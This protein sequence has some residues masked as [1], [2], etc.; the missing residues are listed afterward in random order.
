MNTDPKS[1]HSHC[2]N[3]NTGYRVPMNTEE[4]LPL[5]Q[6]VA[7]I[8]G[9][10]SS[11]CSQSVKCK[12]VSRTEDGNITSEKS[13]KAEG[14]GRCVMFWRLEVKW[15]EINGS[16]SAFREN[17][18]KKKLELHEINKE[19]C[20]FLNQLLT[21]Y[22][23]RGARSSLKPEQAVAGCMYSSSFATRLKN[24]AFSVSSARSH[25]F[26]IFFFCARVE[27]NRFWCGLT[28]PFDASVRFGEL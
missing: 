3:M 25:L 18:T 15:S 17:K 28:G 7:Y 10:L 23:L 5:Q 20:P 13:R 2:R 27:R 11:T 21:E 12:L 6:L 19:R 14:N 8:F 26:F 9:T 16:S 4:N 1:R 22:R 24:I